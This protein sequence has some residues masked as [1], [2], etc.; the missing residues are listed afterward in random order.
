MIAQE[1]QIS[2]LQLTLLK[3]RT[4]VE[5]LK[6]RLSMLVAFSCAFGYGLA[7][8]G[9]VHWE[10]LCMLTLGG[11]LLSGA[12]I[13]INQ[14]IERDLD[15]LM[16]RTMKRLIFWNSRNCCSVR[17]SRA[18]RSFCFNPTKEPL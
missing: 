17:S 9:N 16:S 6:V 14:V 15:K 11:F 5:L 7:T 12:S 13:G 2:G 8:K 1:L 4:F 3:A 10:T 18:S